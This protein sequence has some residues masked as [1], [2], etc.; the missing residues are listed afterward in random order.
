MKLKVLKCPECRANLEIEDDRTSC[1]CQYCGCKIILDS[2]KQEYTYSKNV[3]VN[4]T[5]HK[6][7]TNDADII[8]AK[9]EASKDSRDFKQFLTLMGLLLLIPIVVFVGFQINGAVSRHEGKINAGYYKDL[10]GKDYETVTAHFEAA[11]FTNIELIDLDDS[12]LAFWNEGKVDTISVGG[13][14]DFESVDWF[15]PDTKVVISYH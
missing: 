4:K 6:R 12:G 13:D 7:Y 9:N 10:I 5:I 1:Y 14:T 2:E 15:Y 11:G 3:N 8:R